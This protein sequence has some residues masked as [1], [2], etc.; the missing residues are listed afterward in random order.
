MEMVQT[1]AMTVGLAAI[2]I[3]LGHA[4]EW[5]FGAR[6]NRRLFLGVIATAI[7]FMA[8]VGTLEQTF[9]PEFPPSDAMLWLY[10]LA[11]VA[12]V[13]AI[14]N[15]LVRKAFIV[16]PLRVALV[17]GGTYLAVSPLLDGIWADGGWTRVGVA[18][19]A[20]LAVWFG[21]DRLLDRD[22]R[23]ASV[24]LG[25]GF[26]AAGGAAAIAFVSSLTIGLSAASLAMG[27]GATALLIPAGREI[28]A[29]GLVELYVPLLGIVYVMAHGYADFAAF[30]TL[31]VGLAPLLV[32]VGV[33]LAKKSLWL[34]TGVRILAVLAPIAVATPLA[35]QALSAPADAEQEVDEDGSY[36]P[37]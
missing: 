13:V 36:R 35:E 8:V 25:L 28:S 22:D 20:T 6:R 3:L 1:V 26:A 4:L 37:Y 24:P 15:T 7:A 10:W 33:P 32:W 16:W 2:I 14:V 11:P 18:V 23:D 17:A 27:I 30:P 31:L 34:R 21:L 5:F 19:V 12:A 29:R 9:V